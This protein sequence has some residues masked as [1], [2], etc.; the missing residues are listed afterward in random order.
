MRVQFFYLGCTQ[1]DQ[2]KIEYASRLY[3]IVFYMNIFWYS[4]C[5]SGSRLNKKIQLG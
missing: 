2:I 1:A 5:K 3:Y 4:W